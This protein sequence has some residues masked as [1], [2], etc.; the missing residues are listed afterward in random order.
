ML[1]NVMGI[2]VNKWKEALDIKKQLL[3]DAE[4]VE[5]GEKEETTYKT[6]IV[7]T[8]SIAYDKCT[9]YILDKEGVEY[10]DETESKRGYK[11]VEKEFD[12]FFQELVKAGYTI[13]A[14]AHV[15]EK[16]VKDKNGTKYEVTQ[17]KIDKRG[18][19]VLSGLCDV[20]GYAAPEEDED[21]NE[22]M[23]LTMRGSKYLTAGS[24]SKYMS[25]KIPFTYEALLADMEQAIDKEMSNNNAT[26]VDTP[27]EVYK[28]QSPEADFGEVVKEVKKV[29]KAFNAQEQM[30]SYTKIA[31]K[32]L[33][34]GRKVQDC[35]ESQ[36][37]MLLLILDDL[38]DKAE[39]LKIE[40]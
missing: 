21:G 20:I 6:V 22:Q 12:T 39:E 26:V 13:V 8:A 10:L 34:K 18:L 33:G 15:D 38:K 29:A 19:A 7:D 36:L 1:P 30:A 32:H 2:P 17:P 14:I 27:T 16:T 28:D 4:A 31:E 24:R 25:E 23:M 40:L 11:A 3:K 5:K 9:Q 37:D 35:T